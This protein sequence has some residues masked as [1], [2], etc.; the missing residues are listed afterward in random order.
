L[1]MLHSVAS[2]LSL[3]WFKLNSHFL[4]GFTIVIC[5]TVP[6][7]YSEMCC[8]EVVF[9]HECCLMKHLVFHDRNSFPY[10]LLVV[11][12]ECYDYSMVRW[13][14]NNV[15]VMGQNTSFTIF[16]YVVLWGCAAHW[17]TKW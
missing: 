11:M 16:R 12:L 2:S 13:L 7:F 3:V 10:K 4:K 14:K 15:A 9:L 8:F 1:A 5:D 17:P 6:W